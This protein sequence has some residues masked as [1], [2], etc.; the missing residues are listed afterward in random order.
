[1]MEDAS[2]K[3]NIKMKKFF[4][5]PKLV[6]H[7]V[8]NFGTLSDGSIVRAYLLASNGKKY[9]LYCPKDCFANGK[10]DRGCGSLIICKKSNNYYFG[11]NKLNNKNR[12]W[13]NTHNGD[14]N[15]NNEEIV[16]FVNAF[17]K[18]EE[19]TEKYL[20]NV[21][22]KIE[23]NSSKKAKKLLKEWKSK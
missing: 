19:I 14:T 3:E 9:L 7:V 13:R 15:F 2:G 17:I 21:I 10:I 6:F 16:S 12:C 20:Y 8:Y 18:N 23:K 5:K 4:S 11:A 1:M 22:S